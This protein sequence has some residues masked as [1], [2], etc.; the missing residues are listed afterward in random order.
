MNQRKTGLITH[1]GCDMPLKEAESLNIS[2]IPDRILFGNEE[3]RNMFDITAEE[4]YDKLEQASQLPTS[5]RPTTAD[6]MNAFRK[7]G[8]NSEEILCLMITSK[9]SACYSAALS[10]SKMIERRGFSVPIYVYDTKQCSH[11][12]AQLVRQASRL[13]DQGLSAEQIISQ[14]DKLQNRM[15]VYFVL[16]SLKNARK[17]GRVGAI[18][19]LTADALGIKPMLR[20]SD[21]LV[22][23]F[24][25][26]KNFLDG[27][28]Q[29][30]KIAKNETDFHYPITVFHAS[31]P[32]RAEEIKKQILG[33][34][35][36]ASIGIQAVGPVIGIYTGSGCAGMAF[37]KKDFL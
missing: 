23:D 19:A 33:F 13:A 18:K 1:T 32:E 24:G 37:T 10:A 25:L 12:M 3:Y 14:L 20:F 31:A 22:R 16:E 36:N 34:A 15:G 35:P 17:G 28:G 27:I 9:M 21:G 26:A 4:F 8:E 29:L 7:V 6:F 2:V 30:M 11:G 5:S